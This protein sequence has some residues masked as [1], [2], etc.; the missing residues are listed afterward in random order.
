[1]DVLQQ[2]LRGLTALALAL[3]SCGVEAE[4]PEARRYLGDAA[5]RRAALVGSLV[6]RDNA[7]ARLRLARYDSGDALDW[8]RLPVWNP[9][10]AVGPR[11]VATPLAVD[12]AATDGDEA[13]LRA[14]GERAFVRY[15]AMLLSPPV[16]MAL[17]DEGAWARY[18][19]RLPTAGAGGG[20]VVRVALP[21][22]DVGLALTCA[23]CHSA[24]TPDGA[25]VAGVANGSLDLGALTADA[26]GLLD[27]AAVT[28]LRAW[29]PGRVDVSTDD[30]T[31][32]LAMPDLRA[33]RY[34]AHLHRAGAV[35]AGSLAALAVRVETLLVTS[36]REAVRPPREVALGLAVY[37]RS[38][39]E[40][41]P[42]TA[43]TSGRGAAVFAARCGGCHAGEGRAGGLVTPEAADT[44][45]WV[46]RSPAR[47]TG[48]YRVPSLRG[49]GTRGRLLH[50]GS[51][52]DVGALLDPARGG[53]HRVGRGL[54]AGD[55]A[56]LADFVRAL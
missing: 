50:D 56:A 54:D 6:T 19:L 21:G 14:L 34:Q 30:G 4:E 29:G 35:R 45:A 55:R 8:S 42:R 17:R 2:R 37:L 52:T 16:E 25:L 33:V 49:V 12:A 48:F 51:V 10:A 43:A 1:M 27:P 41:M 31:E 20:D 38:L 9:P 44:E 39:G 32:P 53:W 36:H 26:N 23:A 15:P 5:F 3:A 22:G 47:G 24:R 18:G 46:A 40:A 7:Y 11:D 13:A 28:R